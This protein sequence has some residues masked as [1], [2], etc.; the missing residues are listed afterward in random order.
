MLLRDSLASIG[1]QLKSTIMRRTRERLFTAPSTSRGLS[2]GLLIFEGEDLDYLSRTRQLQKTLKEQFDQQ[3][4]EKRSSMQTKREVEQQSHVEYMRMNSLFGQR[5][6]QYKLR[7]RQKLE[8]LKTANLHLAR[9]KQ[10]KLSRDRQEQIEA[11]TR[12]FSELARRR[13]N[14]RKGL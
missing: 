5:E 7:Y 10:A 2:S 11:E 6:E 3:I 13:T 8:D 14:S 9:E 4:R 1:E 12:L